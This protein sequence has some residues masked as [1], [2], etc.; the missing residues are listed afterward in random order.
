MKKLKYKAIKAWGGVKVYPNLFV[1]SH[2]GG[3]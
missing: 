1:M 2:Y 3:K